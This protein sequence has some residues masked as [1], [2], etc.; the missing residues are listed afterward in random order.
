MVSDISGRSYLTLWKQG[1]TSWV[2]AETNYWLVEGVYGRGL[3]T[4][5]TLH[6]HHCTDSDCKWHRP[7]KMAAFVSETL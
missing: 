1:G 6:D 4:T 5:A 3:D 7:H 2:T